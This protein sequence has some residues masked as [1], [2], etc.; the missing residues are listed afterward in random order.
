MVSPGAPSSDPARPA[1][2]ALSS[3]NQEGIST[4]KA[5]VEAEQMILPS[6]SL[7]TTTIRPHG[8]P[9]S[10]T[11]PSLGALKT[12]PTAAGDFEA[13]PAKANIG[14]QA[15]FQHGKD[16]QAQDQDLQEGGQIMSVDRSTSELNSNTYSFTG[17]AMTI[18]DRFFTLVSQPDSGEH[19]TDNS[20]SSPSLDVL[21]VTGYTM[22]SNP[23]GILIHGFSVITGS[24]SPTIPVNPTSTNPSGNLKLAS[25]STTVALQHLFTIGTQTFSANLNG[26]ALSDADVNS[27]GS[28]QTI[29]DTV[30]RLGHSG[31][32]SAQHAQPTNDVFT[33]DD[34][35]LTPNL[36]VPPMTAI[37]ITAGGSAIIIYGTTVSLQPSGK[38]VVGSS[39]IFY[40][41]SAASQASQST[42]S[43]KFAIDGLGLQV[44][45]SYVVVDGQNL[46]PGAHG[47]TVSINVVNPEPGF[48]T[49]NTGGG[50]ST[51]PS[52]SVHA[53]VSVQTLS[54]SGQGD[55]T[56]VPF[57]LIFSIWPSLMLLL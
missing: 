36:S 28:A 52:N 14:S 29:D 35:T 20:R 1:L 3:R 56:V 45:S 5:N 15:A 55:V 38:L 23:S 50:N 10:V 21:G 2:P 51:I 27:G 11:P 40:P 24:D 30:V 31:A 44:Q 18:S 17:P 37:M 32:L 8:E 12:A 49:L 34:P 41:A 39:V 33:L 16:P 57:F 54:Q 43:T 42:Q 19:I 4:A 53:A 46:Q 13:S 26:L 22:V 25:F 47:T 9:A 6:G 7:V 48:K